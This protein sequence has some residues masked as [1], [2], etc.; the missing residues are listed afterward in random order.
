MRKRWNDKLTKIFNVKCLVI[1]WFLCSG[2]FAEAQ[3]IQM[4][5]PDLTANVNDT[6]EIPVYVDNSL[7]G[8]NILSYQL[9]V[10]FNSNLI[11]FHSIELTG[12]LSQIWGYPISNII[13]SDYLLLANAGS[14]PLVGT[15]ELLI[16]KFITKASGW[17]AINFDGGVFHNFFNEGIPPMTFDNG[18]VN[19]IPMPVI[20]VSPDN[21]LLAVG[22]QIQFYVS[23]G[24]PPYTWS[25][26]DPLVGLIDN[27]GLLNATHHGM[28]KI[29]CQDSEGMT[30]E[31]NGEIEIRAVSLTIPDTTEW[32]GATIEIPIYSSSLDGLSILSGNIGLSFNG[33]ILFPV[34]YI[35]N[36]TLL[37]SYSN[38][39]FNN[40]VPSELEIAFAGT[41]PLTGSGILLFIQFDIST[42]NTGNSSISFTEA[43]FNETLP[44]KT[45]N[46]YF[47]MITY[48]NIS[49]TPNSYTLV[50][51]ETK[52]FSVNGGVAP[53]TWSTSDP[54]VATIDATG[55][56][57]AHMSGIIQIQVEDN[58][59]A[60]GSTGNIAVFD[61]YLN[62]ANSSAIANSIYNLPVTITDIPAGQ[63]VFSLQG[64]FS[65]ESPELSALDIVTS[66]S[67]TEGW[68]FAKTIT[69]N[70]IS[71]AGAGTNG[72]NT[73]GTIFLIS[74]QLT[75]DMTVGENAW[76]NIDN[77]TLNE[78]IPLPLTQNGS[79]TCVSGFQVSLKV[80][81]EGPFNGTQMNSNLI[82]G[83]FIPLSQPYNVYPWN[84]PGNESVASIPTSNIVDWLLIEL[85]DSPDA[86]TATSSTMIARQAAFLTKDGIVT[87]LDGISHL[88]F[89]STINE[90]LF[91]VIW[92]RNHLGILSAST[93]NIINGGYSYDFTGSS[94]QFYGGVLACKELSPDLWGMVGGDGNADN[95]VS[96]LDKIDVWSVQAG[97]SGYLSGD[98][99]VD[100]QVNN[101]DKIDVWSPN[102]GRA[103][104][105][106]QP[107][108]FN[109]GDQLI[110]SRDGQTYSTVH[111][112]NQCWMAENLNIGT[113]ITGAQTNNGTIER[114]CYDN[115]YSSCDIYGG[116]YQW[117]EM[118]Q[119]SSLAGGQG[120][121]PW[122]WHLPTDEEWKQLQSEADSQ[123][124]YP[125]PI[126]DIVGWRGFDAGFNLKS[127]NGWASGGNGSDLYG[128]TALPGG[129]YFFNGNDLYSRALFWSSDEAGSSA[130]WGVE[131]N[132][133]QNGVNRYN[134]AK[135]LGFS[136]RCL[137]N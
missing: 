15:G 79:I 88:A 47:T 54:A 26:S 80:F 84:Y 127:T 111:I 73:S 83:G 48:G 132:S 81:L 25:L 27:N 19:I 10:Y 102:S 61:T 131:L 12:S 59:G 4:R 75:P 58:V 60:V 95:Q 90:S 77:I 119:Y 33:D 46:G 24:T 70:Q 116:L 114:F 85:R 123:Y 113:L 56:L 36:G 96:N 72:F 44:A 55:L 34:G 40:N 11:Q 16:I 86:S 66:G 42:I 22:E 5:F 41:V 137:K 43:E 51:G 23:G 104:Q 65:F 101:L 53:Y 108:V 20:T 125:D 38:I 107:V 29:I 121:C 69:S 99:S 133:G 92:H 134:H 14:T 30:D 28:T 94:S 17:T 2:F 39:A 31:T 21:G 128:F 37:E 97:N 32:Q 62:V 71:F 45:S 76:V 49:I 74:F 7:T 136:V 52:Q 129:Y 1:F 8:N 50:A 120:I 93:L 89:N 100:A 57:T 135:D 67:M 117:D 122:G 106:P 130:A 35:T 64:S 63:N 91:V 109:C 110:D 118:M 105:I 68:T 115:S 112:G 78:G 103:S 9:R 18:S 124:G 87:G 13:N 126:W 6:I 3:S 98:F 82:S